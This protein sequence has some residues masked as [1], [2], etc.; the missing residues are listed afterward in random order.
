MLQHICLNVRLICNTMSV[1]HRDHKG[2]PHNLLEEARPELHHGRRSWVEILRTEKSIVRKRNYAKSS[3]MN[4]RNELGIRAL[5][6]PEDWEASRKPLIPADL[7][8]RMHQRAS[9]SDPQRANQGEWVPL[10][11]WSDRGRGFPH[12]DRMSGMEQAE[13]WSCGGHR[14][15]ALAR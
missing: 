13:A 9:T 1:G 4:G 8:E 5:G 15:G 14:V 7:W 11:W 10:L 2:V 6:T 12:A 3:W